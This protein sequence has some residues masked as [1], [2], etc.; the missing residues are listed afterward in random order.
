MNNEPLYEQPA[1]PMHRP[2]VSVR[3]CRPRDGTTTAPQVPAVSPRCAEAR[4]QRDPEASPPSCPCE[5]HRAEA[6]HTH[7][8]DAPGQAAVTPETLCWSSRVV[9]LC[10]SPCAG[11]GGGTR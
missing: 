7:V 2:A 3:S 10:G 4:R 5:R 1:L 9:G 11:L 8:T 6:G